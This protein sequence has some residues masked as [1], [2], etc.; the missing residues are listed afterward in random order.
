MGLGRRKFLEYMG[1]ALTG[2][3]ID[4]LQSVAINEDHYVNKKFGILLTKPKGW[5]F[6]SVT[7]FGKLRADQ[8]LSDAYEP[9]KEE[10]WKEL[11]DPVLVIA[12]HGLNKPGYD[13][14][15][16]PA[17]TIF[18]NHK[19]EVLDEEDDEDGITDF[20][21]IVG[22]IVYGSSM[23][24][25]DYEQVRYQT[26][27]T[28]SSCRAYDGEWTFTFESIEHQKAYHCR[29]WSIIVEKNDL[30]YSF[31]MIDSD[32]AGENEQDTFRKFVE[33][34]KIL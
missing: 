2:I 10:V 19:S 1:I 12:K 26:P 25:K 7:D 22:M 20:E 3:T 6:V 34:I 15:F 27:Y 17:I 30:I 13:D 21:Q 5:E 16:S 24:F 4:P 31:N 14:K 29:A 23:I 28:L 11:G 33:T 32:E 8:M 18:I 9:N